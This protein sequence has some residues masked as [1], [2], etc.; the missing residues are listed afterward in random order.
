M[1]MCAVVRVAEPAKGPIKL[2][3][4]AEAFLVFFP[5]IEESE[6][7]DSDHFSPPAPRRVAPAG[8]KFFRRLAH[9]AFF[10]SLPGR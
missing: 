1:W 10:N 8:A 5:S 3:P 2:L 6:A 7:S 4:E 9:A